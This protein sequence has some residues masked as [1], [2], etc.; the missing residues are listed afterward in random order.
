MKQTP[1]QLS[2]FGA[3]GQGQKIELIGVLEKLFGQI[4]ALGRKRAGKVREGFALPL[5]QPGRDVTYEDI[6]TPSVF[7]G[8]FQ[9]PFPCGAILD[10]VQKARLMAPRQL[11]Q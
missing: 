2:F 1:L 11:L 6:L 10:R 4:G 3:G 9:I 7:D 5:V 8:C